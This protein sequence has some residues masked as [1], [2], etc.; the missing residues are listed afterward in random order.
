VAT[1]GAVVGK[2]VTEAS[3]PT[4]DRPAP[5]LKIADTSGM[6]AV[7][8]EPNMKSSRSRAQARLIVMNLSLSVIT[9]FG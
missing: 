7:M 5:T 1:V 2:V 9:L 8:N 4:T 6:A 3:S